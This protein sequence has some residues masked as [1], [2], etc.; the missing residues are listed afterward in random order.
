M[1]KL[2]E[3]MLKIP[4]YGGY[5]KR[6][7]IRDEDKKLRVAIADAFASQVTRITRVQ[8]QMLKRGDLD[9]LEALDNIIGRLQHLADRIRT[10]SYG[11][12]GMSLHDE[13]PIDETVLT[14]LYDY[15]MT[16]AGG[17]EEM[18]DLMAQLGASDDPA[19]FIT[20][21]ND[22]ID[23]LHVAFDERARVIENP[24]AGAQFIGGAPAPALE[25][26]T[27]PDTFE[28]PVRSEGESPDLSFGGEPP[29]DENDDMKGE[30][31]TMS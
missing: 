15:D 27:P 26:E 30:A 19:G 1:N 18:A 31:P 10:A 22:K 23:A 6:E 11:F 7:N 14:G 24:V 8:E 20:R 4:G 12:E 29:M 16:L 25:N 5:L 21:I 9:N 3:L 17:V 2:G 13:T 28:T